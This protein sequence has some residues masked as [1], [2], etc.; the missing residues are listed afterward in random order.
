MV[1]GR[2]RGNWEHHH[3]DAYTFR[4][5]RDLIPEIKIILITLHNYITVI[6]LHENII[7]IKSQYVTYSTVHLTKNLIEINR[8]AT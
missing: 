2:R 8:I 7:F 3:S 6:L 5:G 4:I 1:G